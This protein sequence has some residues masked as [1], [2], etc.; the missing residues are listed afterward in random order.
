MGVLACDLLHMLRQFCLMGEEAK[1]SIE[2]L[3]KRLISLERG[4]RIMIGGG[5]FMSRRSFLWLDITALYSGEDRE[6][7]R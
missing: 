3:I 7:F 2:R 6:N 4:C 5:S 1:R